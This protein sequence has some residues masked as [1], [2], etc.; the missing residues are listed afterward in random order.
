MARRVQRFDNRQSMKNKYFE[1]FYYKDK[2]PES[3][4]IHHHEFYEIYFFLNGDVHFTIE[5]KSYTLEHGDL[6]LMSPMELHQAQINPET[7]YERIVLWIDC[8]Y[9]KKLGGKKTN[10]ASCFDRSTPNYTNYI[11]ADKLK[12]TTLLALFEKI[13]KEFYGSH[14]G[15]EQYAKALL[16]QLMIE[17]N[18]LASNISGTK[19]E[20]D[21]DL[22]SQVL[23]YIGENFMQPITLESLANKFFVS[24]YY[25]SHEF[26]HRVGTSIY[27]YVIFR[28]LMQAK[29]MIGDGLAP[30]DVSQACGFGDYTNFYRAFKAEFGISPKQY[31]LTKRQ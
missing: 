7:V 26:Q 8:D 5:G 6:L 1:I 25:L 17:I 29:E 24:K 21:D 16:I 31:A 27:R 30:G 13:N 22:I 19:N 2:K 10:L 3:V 12:Q 20:E 15:N 23:N 4:S 14:F 18:R 28:R 9:L 11:K